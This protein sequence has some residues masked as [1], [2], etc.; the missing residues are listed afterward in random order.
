MN[1]ATDCEISPVRFVLAVNRRIF[2]RADL[3]LSVLPVRGKP[4]DLV[5]LVRPRGYHARNIINE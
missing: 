1:A 2:T 3:P 5:P 4:L